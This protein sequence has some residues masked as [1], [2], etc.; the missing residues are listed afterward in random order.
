M[1]LSTDSSSGPY[2]S[3]RRTMGMRGTKRPHIFESKCLFYNNPIDFSK[4]KK[5]NIKDSTSKDDWSSVEMI[6]F[7]GSVKKTII[8]G[9]FDEWATE[10]SIYLNCVFLMKCLLRPSAEL[11]PYLIWERTRPNLRESF[12]E[13]R[14]VKNIVSTLFKPRNAFFLR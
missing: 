12:S 5:K 11:G 10:V 7:M 8:K 14:F 13:L 2:S 9:N 3:Q 1:C 4:T 6:E